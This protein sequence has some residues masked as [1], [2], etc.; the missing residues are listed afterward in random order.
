MNRSEDNKPDND[1]EWF[2]CLSCG[3]VAYGDDPEK[4]KSSKCL[5]CGKIMGLS[6]K[7]PPKFLNSKPL[8]IECAKCHH[9]YSPRASACPKCGF[10]KQSTCV[11]CSKKIPTISKICPYCA[12]PKPFTKEEHSPPEVI[13]RYDETNQANKKSNPKIPKHVTKTSG[14]KK[15]AQGSHNSPR[16]DQD[17]S[18]INAE[19]YLKQN[20]IVQE[21]EDKTVIKRILI[22]VPFVLFIM[23]IVGAVQELM[24]PG[25]LRGAIIVICF[26]SIFKFWGW[27]KN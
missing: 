27:I 8:M 16:L 23:L 24:Q 20:Q 11:I 10:E 22:T 2:K 17:Q 3:F 6:T 4:A 26:L 25:L 15:N 7:K 14:L 12:D 5:G 18:N 13:T 9:H 21:T 1:T 19:S